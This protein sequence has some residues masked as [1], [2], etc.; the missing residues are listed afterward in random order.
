MGTEKHLS[1]IRESLEVYN[2][3]LEN[4]V[5]FI[6]DNCAVNQRLASLASVPIIGCAAHKFKLA[7]E[8]WC[9]DLCGL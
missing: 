7:V 2:M 4:V 8:A 6:S 1:F 5:D 9:E 3:R